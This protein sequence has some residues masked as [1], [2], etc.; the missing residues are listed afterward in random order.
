MARPMN[1]EGR[2]LMGCF[3]GAS[4]DEQAMLEEFVRSSRQM[5]ETIATLQNKLRALESDVDSGAQDTAS[6][7]HALANL[8]ENMLA[9]ADCTRLEQL[10]Q[11]REEDVTERLASS[12]KVAGELSRLGELVKQTSARL[13]GIEHV[14]EWF[15]LLE[16]SLHGLDGKIGAVEIGLSQRASGD[17]MKILGNSVKELQGGLNKTVLRVG[18]LDDLDL[19]CRTRALEASLEGLRQKAHEQEDA[20]K[21]F[22]TVEALGSHGL[23]IDTLRKVVDSKARAERQEQLATSLHVLE[24]KVQEMLQDLSEQ[25]AAKAEAE[26]VVGLERALSSLRQLLHS[27]MEACTRAIQNVHEAVD[28]KADGTA[29][30]ELQEH[31]MRLQELSEEAAKATSV[32]ELTTRVSQLQEALYS[33][34]DQETLQ[35]L[36]WEARQLHALLEELAQDKASDDSVKQLHSAVKE[37]RVDVERLV[38]DVAAADN[39]SDEL[40]RCSTT[41]RRD[42]VQATS[43]IQSQ[44]QPVVDGWSSLQGDVQALQGASTA[45]QKACEERFKQCQSLSK[46][47]RGDLDILLP[48]QAAQA[49]QMDNTKRSLEDLRE[50]SGQLKTALEGRAAAL[51]LRGLEE[52]VR[53]VESSVTSMQIATNSSVGGLKNRLEHLDDALAAV[54]MEFASCKERLVHAVEQGSALQTANASLRVDFSQIDALTRKMHEQMSPALEQLGDLSIAVERVNADCGGARG[55]L[56]AHSRTLVRL[57]RC[58][59]QLPDLRDLANEAKEVSA[60]VSSALQE[61][62]SSLQKQVEERIIFTNESLKGQVDEVR[63]RFDELAVRLSTAEQRVNGL[64]VAPELEQMKRTIDSMLVSLPRKASLAHLEQLQ[65]MVEQLSIGFNGNSDTLKS[66]RLLPGRVEQAV[67]KSG[68]LEKRISAAE[69]AVANCA[70]GDE[71]LSFQFAMT[72]ATTDLKAQLATKVEAE[73]VDDLRCRCEQRHLGKGVINSRSLSRAEINGQAGEELSVQRPLMQLTSRSLADAKD[74]PVQSK[75]SATMAQPPSRKPPSLLRRSRSQEPGGAAFRATGAL[76]YRGGA[77]PTAA[78]VVGANLLVASPALRRGR[79]ASAVF[80]P[81]LDSRSVRSRQTAP[82][83]FV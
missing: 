49:E 56:D 39:R 35:Q 28:K 42:F 16:A 74:D 63:G 6:L 68:Q 1:S 83:L 26:A 14:P 60:A 65:R 24:G 9:K 57:E 2:G 18:A 51:E 34:A 13:D 71:F 46:R 58:V 33:K 81:D 21:K 32:Q 75:P 17:D 59:L 72:S 55:Q 78:D 69:E 50:E 31:Q 45:L 66:L 11:H 40:Q 70:A 53:S 36:G 38:A 19:P 22:A 52:A 5:E 8:E 29:L 47:N 80:T 77:M 30:L 73:V 43:A 82:D 37:L 48:Q 25:R 79:L 76:A 4:M 54:N 64:S 20:L 27:E 62:R 61:L 67:A 23:A 15:G 44:V 3:F 41:L 7:S 12:Q 10:E